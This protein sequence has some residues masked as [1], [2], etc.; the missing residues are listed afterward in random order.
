MFSTG[1]TKVL[2]T[3]LQKFDNRPNIS[4]SGSQLK[5]H[6][7]GT[8]LHLQNLQS[9][10]AYTG[11]SNQRSDSYFRDSGFQ[12]RNFGNQSKHLLTAR[13]QNPRSQSALFA[14][15]TTEALKEE[16]KVESEQEKLIEFR[17]ETPLENIFDFDNCKED[18]NIFM[19]HRYFMKQYLQKV[20]D[21]A[22][23]SNENNK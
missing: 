5:M 16:S 21:V 13:P 3:N 2:A 15:A 20:T 1:N 22:N 11:I 9:S 12:Q 10:S 17:P 19:E 4:S 14:T 23:L 7:S 8:P 18:T 6:T